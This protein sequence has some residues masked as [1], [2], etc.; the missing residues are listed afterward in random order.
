MKNIFGVLVLI[1]TMWTISACSSSST[2]E[3]QNE[4]KVEEMVD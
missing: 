1:S 3:E 2:K 4:E